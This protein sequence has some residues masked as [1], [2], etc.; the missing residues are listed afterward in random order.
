MRRHFFAVGIMLSAAVLLLVSCE[1]DDPSQTANQGAELFRESFDESGPWE[2][3]TYPAEEPTSSLAIVNGRYRIDHE[4]EPGASFIWGESKTLDDNTQN[5]IIEVQ[6]EQISTEKDNLYGVLCRLG[7]DARGN[8]T[9]Y[10]LLISGDGHFGIAELRSNSLA[11][12]LAWH[13]TDVIRQGASANTIRAVCV[14]DYLALYVNDTFL[15]DIKDTMYQRSGPI[16]LIAGVTE[17]AAISVTFDDL[18]VYEGALS[19]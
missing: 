5:V 2:E 15:G 1:K 18:T 17:E 10:A 6:V 11:F 13:Q 8:A 16:G 12:L 7:E 14:E 19:D 3:G 9:G 4:S